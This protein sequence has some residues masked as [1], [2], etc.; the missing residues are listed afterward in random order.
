MKDIELKRQNLQKFLD[1][2]KDSL[3]RNLMGQYATPYPLAEQICTKVNSFFNGKI[4]SFLEPSIGTGAFYSALTEIADIN[5]SVGYEIDTHYYIPAKELWKGHNLELINEDF[6]EAEP[7]RMFSL[8]IAN[9]P[10]SRHHHIP[11][12]KKEF[13]QKRIKSEYGIK[14]SGLSGLYC[15]FMILSTKWLKKE[16][17]SCWLVPSEFLSVNYGK[18]IKRFLLENVDLISIHSFD[19]EDVQFDDALVSSSI[20]IFRNRSPRNNTIT[21]TWGNNI[22]NPYKTLHIQ[23]NALDYAE[24]WNGPY[25]GGSSELESA[26]SISTFFT[27]KRGIATGDN[28][29]FIVDQSTIDTFDLP[30]EFLVPVVPP[31]RKLDC[32][33]FDLNTASRNPLYL[34]RTDLSSDI[35]RTKYPGYFNYIN[36][37]IK[38][39]VNLRSNCKSRDIW[40]NCE[41]RDSAPLL[42]SYMGR[43]NGKVPFRFILNETGAIATNSY[44]MIYPRHEF[45]HHFNDLN[46]REKVWKALCSISGEQLM[47]HGRCYGGGLYKL[48]P[49]EL[50]TVPCP[51]LASILPTSTPSLF[52]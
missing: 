12:E 47:A 30:R 52:D 34:I 20:V 28:S 11:K 26:Y 41:Y 38:R 44:L 13:Y 36:E 31:P 4:D 24:K 1:A 15:Y 43:C 17:L 3:Q 22:N 51:Q 14:I 2:Q 25:L 5:K 6:L 48:E 39:G 27:I 37:G 35:I 23:R 7:E 8:I 49:K 50:G 10:Y 40:Y 19:N 33:R 32:D 9:P 46:V 18:E 16:G 21:F 29:F 45:K 42:I